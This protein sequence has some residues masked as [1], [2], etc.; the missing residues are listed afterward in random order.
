[1]IGTAPFDPVRFQTPDEQKAWFDTLAK[2]VAVDFDGVLHPYTD[3][4][5]GSTPADE[6][7]TPGAREFLEALAANGYVVVVFSTRCDHPEGLDGT[8]GWLDRHGLLHF[9][10]RVT[11]EKPAAVAYVDDRAV[12]FAGDWEAVRAGVERLADGRSHGAGVQ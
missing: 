10:D 3:G 7:P 9:V 12:P 2:T 8:V 11:H 4:W 5:V 6:P 1:M